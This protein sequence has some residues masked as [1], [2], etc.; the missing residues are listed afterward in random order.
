MPR[1]SR[2]ASA[3]PVA[4]APKTFSNCMPAGN[5]VATG[6]V[7]EAPLALAT[8]SSTATSEVKRVPSR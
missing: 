5:S 6:T 7:V 1:A 2:K 8:I 3:V 4:G